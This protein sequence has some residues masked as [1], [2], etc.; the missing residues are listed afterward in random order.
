[1]YPHLAHVFV[2]GAYLRARAKDLGRE[3][4]NPLSLAK[5]L[6]ESAPVQTWAYDPTVHP[7]ALLGRTTYYDAL[8]EQILRKLGWDPPHAARVVRV[9]V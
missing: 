6:L 4:F 7:N 1:M 2:D 5:G 3:L 9:T 8:A